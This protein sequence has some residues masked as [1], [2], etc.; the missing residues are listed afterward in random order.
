MKNNIRQVREALGVS[1]SDLS[2]RMG[3]TQVVVSKMESGNHILRSSTLDRVSEALECHWTQ[4]LEPDQVQEILGHAR[5]DLA[6]SVR[7]ARGAGLT[8]DDI[9]EIVRAKRAS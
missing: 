5:E 1:Q 7:R 8:Q 6:H 9:D 4:L 3:V 2:R